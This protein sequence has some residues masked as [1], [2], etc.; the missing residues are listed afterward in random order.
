[1]LLG[2]FLQLRSLECS[3]WTSA[4]SKFSFYRSE[5]VSGK[6]PAHKWGGMRT[7][8]SWSSHRMWGD[9][10]SPNAINVRLG[11][12][13]HQEH[14]EDKWKDVNTWE[15]IW[16]MHSLPVRLKL[17]FCLIN[18]SEHVRGLLWVPE[19]GGW[20]WRVVVWLWGCHSLRARGGETLEERRRWVKVL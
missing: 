11:I 5:K 16:H 17:R 19:E 7:V 12:P 10:Q 9:T 14:A 18:N 15:H 3:K 13:K 8:G 2:R 1:M 6:F 20:I 4:S